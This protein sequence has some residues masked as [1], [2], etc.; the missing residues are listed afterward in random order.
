MWPQPPI[1]NNVVA[2]IITPNSIHCGWITTYKKNYLYLSAYEMHPIECNII[3]AI[4]HRITQFVE[5][6]R[7]QHSFCVVALSAPLMYEEL[8]R[9]SKA[10]PILIDFSNKS[11]FQLL[12]DYHY[13]HGLDDGNHLFYVRGIK[14]S[15]L[16]EYELLAKQADLLLTAVT[17]QYAAQL[18][19]YARVYGPAFRQSQRTL[20]LIKY[21]YKIAQSLK[22][23]TLAH[24]LKIDTQLDCTVIDSEIRATLIGMYYQ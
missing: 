4:R 7:L 18:N 8:V 6:H 5:K 19:A 24:L 13:L 21:E 17:S 10:S 2:I 15:V 1:R 22:K 3:P 9:L 12:W 20:D 11:L 16:F 23:E 14:K